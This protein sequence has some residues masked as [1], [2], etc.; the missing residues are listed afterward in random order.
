MSVYVNVQDL[1]N[2]GKT[3]GGGS[4]NTNPYLLSNTNTYTLNSRYISAGLVFRFG[5]MELER[6]ARE[7]AESDG[8]S[9][10]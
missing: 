10:E 2:W 3:I 4:T 7:G 1:F 9:M 8:T 6:N 5:K